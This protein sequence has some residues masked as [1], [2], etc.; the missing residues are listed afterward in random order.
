MKNFADEYSNLKLSCEKGQYKEN[1]E[2][3]LNKLKNNQIILY[4]AGALGS[5]VA[6]SMKNYN[7]DVICF[8]DGHKTGIHNE[9]GLPIVSSESLTDIYSGCVIVVTSIEYESEIKQN[10]NALGIE[11]ERVVS[12]LFYNF[13]KLSMTEIENLRPGYEQAY[14]VLSDEESRQIVLGKLKCFLTASP[15]IPKK[16]T[17]IPIRHNSL[18]YFDED[19]VMLSSDEI[20]V[21]GGMSAGDVAQ[22]LIKINKGSY[23]HY[24]GF[25]PE[26]TC[27]DAA[28]K[29][30][31]N[32][33]NITLL[34]KGLWSCN[35]QLKFNVLPSGSSNVDDLGETT[36]DV[37]D[38]DTFFLDKAPPTFIKMDIEGAEMSALKGAERIIRNFKPKLAICVYHNHEDV[39][40]LTELIQ[41]FRN[42]YQFYIR[43]YMPHMYE[44]VLYAV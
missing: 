28:I 38:I 16:I 29:N 21:D 12:D 20:L 5:I 9:T 11:P 35:A 17:P 25:E 13:H 30:L 40:L 37:I 34:N 3:M 26:K 6:E 32:K 44:T 14:N 24:Y 33:P 8:C 23:G 41:K 22:Q 7:F 18:Q 42:D 27:F 2:Q 36:I 15:L 19:I 4:G 43:H 1:I 39:Y 31:A 10:L